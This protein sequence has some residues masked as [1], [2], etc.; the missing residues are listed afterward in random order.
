MNKKDSEYKKMWKNYLREEK[1]PTEVK[2]P[3][4]L[5]LMPAI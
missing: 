2:V 3:T 5:N 1:E 4:E